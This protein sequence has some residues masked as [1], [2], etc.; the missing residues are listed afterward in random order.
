MG[1]GIWVAIRAGSDLGPTMSARAPS[2]RDRFS[3]VVGLDID[4]ALRGLRGDIRLLERV[5]RSFV[6]N[7]SEGEPVLLEPIGAGMSAAWLAASHSLRGACAAV[8]ATTLEHALLKFELAV[9]AS[10]G[11]PELEKQAHALQDGLMNFVDQ[12]RRSLSRASS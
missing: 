8:G 1:G 9:A 10:P 7:Y 3:D 4:L 12:L 2:L 5:M 11:N 6:N